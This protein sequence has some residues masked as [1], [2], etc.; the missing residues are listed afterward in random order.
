MYMKPGKRVENVL[1]IKKKMQ[2]KSLL[3][4]QKEL[5]ITHMATIPFNYAK[6]IMILTA[7]WTKHQ[8]FSLTHNLN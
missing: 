4:I 1:I 6:T 5:K 3:S 2:C 8:G 7:I